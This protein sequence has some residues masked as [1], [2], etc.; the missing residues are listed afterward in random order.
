MAG[1]ARA[2]RGRRRRTLRLRRRAAFAPGRG[3]D[4]SGSGRRLALGRA[5]ASSRRG[6]VGWHGRARRR[7]R[8][9]GRRRRGR[10]RRRSRGELVAAPN[11]SSTLG[12]NHGR[13]RW[14]KREE[15]ILHR[16]RS[17]PE[18]GSHLASDSKRRP[19]RSDAQPADGGMLLSNTASQ[20]KRRSLWANLSKG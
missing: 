13:R 19:V 4:I 6:G 10:R 3:G 1:G 18:R 16:P 11:G 12:A 5:A 17:A 9:R 20:E 8:R 2:I 7:R 14:R 15:V